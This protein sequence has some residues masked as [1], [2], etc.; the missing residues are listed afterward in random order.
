MWFADLQLQKAYVRKCLCCVLWASSPHLHSYHTSHKLL[1]AR[2]WWWK[3]CKAKWRWAHHPLD[4]IVSKC[5]GFMDISVNCVY[6]TLG[7][8]WSLSQ[9]HNIFCLFVCNQRFMK[10]FQLKSL[11]NKQTNEKRNQKAF[12][13]SLLNH[14]STLKHTSFWETGIPLMINFDLRTSNTWANLH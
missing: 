10:I 9:R 8:W 14:R 4:I 7:K 11:N 1:T 12:D 2:D 3:G 5:G 6:S 13:Y